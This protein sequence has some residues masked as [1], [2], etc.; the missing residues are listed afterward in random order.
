MIVLVGWIISGEL[1]LNLL[2]PFWDAWFRARE[3]KADQYAA[4]LGWASDLADLLEREALLDDH[5]IPFRFLSGASHP[6]TEHRI[7]ALRDYDRHQQQTAL[8]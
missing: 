8:P 6:P 3:F 7:Q 1:A 4:R 5:P 2:R